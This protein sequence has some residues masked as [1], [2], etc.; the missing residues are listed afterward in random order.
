LGKTGSAQ[1]IFGVFSGPKRI[2]SGS[3][4]R[5]W[6]VTHKRTDEL[7]LIWIVHFRRKRCPEIWSF[8]VVL[9]THG[10]QLIWIQ[11]QMKPWHTIVFL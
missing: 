3:R 1:C 6:K 11:T 9:R 4:F 10:R 7:Q 5:K 2:N 8:C